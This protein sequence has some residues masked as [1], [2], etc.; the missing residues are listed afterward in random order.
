MV[1]QC[2]LQGACGSTG[3]LLYR[4]QSESEVELLSDPKAES[5]FQYGYGYGYITSKVH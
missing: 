1:S 3:L 4:S 5:Y 2:Y